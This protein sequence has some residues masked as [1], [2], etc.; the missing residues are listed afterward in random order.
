MLLRKTDTLHVHIDLRSLTRERPVLDIAAG[1]SGIASGR[2]SATP[3]KILNHNIPPP[4]KRPQSTGTP[5]W[6]P[7]GVVE[8]VN[9]LTH[10]MGAI[11]P[12]KIKT[13]AA[14]SQRRSSRSSKRSHPDVR[15]LAPSSPIKE[16]GHITSIVPSFNLGL[17]GGAMDLS[18]LPRNF[19]PMRRP[20][21]APPAPKRQH[22]PTWRLHRT[23][24]H[25]GSHFND[26]HLTESHQ[27]EGR[28]AQK[29][30]QA[31]GVLGSFEKGVRHIIA[32]SG[33][34][35]GKRVVV[36]GKSGSV[37]S[38]CVVIRPVCTCTVGICRE[39]YCTC[40]VGNKTTHAL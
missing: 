10:N 20:A 4:T 7:A 8:S 24:E 6:V 18:I 17:H 31:G 23:G 19:H 14:N 38:R 27:D 34:L 12:S 2:I 39:Q 30:E 16:P 25:T 11:S 13:I 29:W 35:A 22:T 26:G 9:A 36:S 28:G 37:M 21:T 3:T 33:K 40:T 1:L 32:T 15:V 5:I